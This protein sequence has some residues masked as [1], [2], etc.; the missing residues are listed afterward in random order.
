MSS[1]TLSL[2]GVT[3][4]FKDTVALDSIDLDV[5]QGELIALLGP[6][7]CGKTTALRIIAGLDRPDSGSVFVGGN[8]VS[9]LSP[10]KRNM[11]MVFQSYSLFPNM[12]A[13]ENVAFGLEMRRVSRRERHSKALELLEMVG[14][15]SHAKR[16]PHQLS[17]GQQQRVALARAL[18]FEPDVLLLDEPLSA[19]DAQVRANL[20]EEIRRLQQ[21]TGT[22]TIF[23]THDQEEAMAMSDRVAVMNH[24]RIAQIAE[25]TALYHFPADA[26][27]A[28][29]VGQMNRISSEIVGDKV[30]VLGTLVPFRKE[31]ASVS[32]EVVALVRPENLSIERPTKGSSANATVRSKI[33]LGALT[34]VTLTTDEGQQITCVLPGQEAM[35]FHAGAKVA[36]KIKSETYLVLDA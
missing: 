16:F 11:G 25:P 19:L 22:T 36:A 5:A 4:R 10:N 3:K 29:F 28:G 23:V 7:G 35:T 15:P 1:S 27:V 12:T 33:F 17:G 31:S 20:R 26:F 34:K 21:E 6:S 32:N 24:G 14:L 30:R 2:R 18:A 8:D 9:E 13:A